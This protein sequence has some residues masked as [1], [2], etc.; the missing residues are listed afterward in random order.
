MWELTAV[1]VLAL[2]ALALVSGSVG[3]PRNALKVV[4]E[5]GTRPRRPWKFGLGVSALVGVWLLICAQGVPLFAALRIKDSEADVTRGNTAAA[6]HAA[7]DAKNLQPWA[8]SPYMQL[9]LVYER[10][11]MLVEARSSIESAIKRDRQNWELWYDA[12]GI[13]L[14]LGNASLAAKSLGRAYSL[15]PQSTVFGAYKPGSLP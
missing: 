3:D 11:G 12:A 6:I 9:A 1:S 7:L 15:N 2:V 4:V 10:E 8:S 5:N 14:K 13:D